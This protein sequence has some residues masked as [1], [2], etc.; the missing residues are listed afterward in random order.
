MP[1]RRTHSLFRQG[2][3]LYELIPN[4]PD[5]RLVPLMQR[6]AEM[7]ISSGLFGGFLSAAK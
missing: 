5:H 2:C 7:L 3:V 1:K 4:T 6:F